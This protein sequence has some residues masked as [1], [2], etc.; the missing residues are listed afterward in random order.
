MNS[1][2]M[3]NP[4]STFSGTHFSDPFL[5]WIKGF[6]KR[7]QAISD[8][9]Q[10]SN[11]VLNYRNDLFPIR[12]IPVSGMPGRVSIS[13]DYFQILSDDGVVNK[14]LT[15]YFSDESRYGNRVGYGKGH[16]LY[17]F[18]E[19][20]F[21]G[22]LIYNIDIYA[23]EWS[24]L[25]IG[26]RKYALPINF[27]W[28]NPATVRIDEKSEEKYLVQKFSIISKKIADYYEYNDHIFSKK[29]SLVFRYLDNHDCPVGNSIK[30][31]QK[32]NQGM[33]FGLLQ[34]RAGNEPENH[35]LEFEMTRYETLTNKWR[36]QNIT[37]VK[38]KRQFSQPVG[39]CGV[40]VSK[41]YEV[42]AY[43]E[44]KKHLNVVRD[45]IISQFTDQ[46]LTQVKS[47]NGFKKSFRIKF[48]GFATNDQIDKAFQ[49]YS[50]MELNVAEFLNAVKDNYDTDTF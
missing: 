36:Q 8:A 7:K 45:Y 11:E 44:Y 49:M 42:F 24:E 37:R 38:V 6:N 4:N 16:S 26:Y 3:T 43:A 46:V 20:V 30:Y 15:A 32:L 40:A 1:L 48:Q 18:F 22:I 13:H 47:K 28:L 33:D 12:S 9:T 23:V 21:Y 34:G 17:Q 25:K 19:S 27:H 10:L 35:S 14:N 2:S 29:D 39:E 5:E 41:Y 50:N 31:L